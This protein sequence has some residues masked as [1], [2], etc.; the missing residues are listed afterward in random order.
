M[1]DDRDKLLFPSR[2]GRLRPHPG[3]KHITARPLP[4]RLWD[5]PLYRICKVHRDPLHFG[6][7]GK[8][9]FDA[10]RGEYRVLYAAEAAEGAFVETCIRDQRPG[11]GRHLTPA[12]LEERKLTEIFFAGP[13]RLVDLTGPG[14]SLLDADSRL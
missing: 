4:L 12:F 13:L 7:E 1:S 14:L 11:G 2:R 8:N 3:P 9:R 6:K 5:A 10:P